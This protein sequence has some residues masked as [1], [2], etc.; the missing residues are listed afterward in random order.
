LYFGD[1][2]SDVRE[3]EWLDRE[4]TVGQYMERTNKPVADFS[5]QHIELG[6]LLEKN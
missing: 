3:F 4:R 5:D 2:F 6:T 1:S